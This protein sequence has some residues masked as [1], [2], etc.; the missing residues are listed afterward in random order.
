MVAQVLAVGGAIRRPPIPQ[1]LPSRVVAA[2][3]AIAV[4]QQEVAFR[5]VEM[6]VVL[7]VV[8]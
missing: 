1:A 4:E 3:T 7:E 5:V 6:Q 2:L 8:L